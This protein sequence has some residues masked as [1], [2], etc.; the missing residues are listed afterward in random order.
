MFFDHLVWL[1]FFFSNLKIASGTFLLGS[2]SLIYFVVSGNICTFRT[3]TQV[4]RNTQNLVSI[5]FLEA[6]Q[7]SNSPFPF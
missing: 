5:R 1:L 7:S 2:K 3:V 4:T 6:A